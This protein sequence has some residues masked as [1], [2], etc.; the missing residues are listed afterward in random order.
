MH[1]GVKQQLYHT[2]GD[3]LNDA[4]A[5]ELMLKMWSFVREMVM[6]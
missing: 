2:V 5:L 4:K 1:C 3:I 6:L